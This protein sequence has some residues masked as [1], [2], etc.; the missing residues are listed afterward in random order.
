MG[1]FLRLEAVKVLE[2]PEAGGLDPVSELALRRREEARIMCGNQQQEVQ[3]SNRFPRYA[4]EV[5]DLLQ[6]FENKQPL[7]M[8]PP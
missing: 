7:V 2:V 1:E 5:H 6:R 4:L 3:S 8:I